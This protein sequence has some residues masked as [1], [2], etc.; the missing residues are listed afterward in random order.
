MPL[1]KSEK[2]Y[3]HTIE[4]WEQQLYDYEPTYGEMVYKRFMDRGISLLPDTTKESLF[5]ILDSS[6][7][8][9]HS[10]L[11][12]STF[13]KNVSEKIMQTARLFNE[14]IFSLEDM[15]KLTLDQ[16]NFIVKE[17][18]ARY[19]M[20]AFGQGCTTGI[21]KSSLLLTDILAILVINLR[22]IQVIASIYGRPA[23]SP[24][25][26]M[27]VLKVF[28]A[29][30]LPKELQGEAW[31][32]LMEDLYKQDYFYKGKEE[33]VDESTF[34]LLVKQSVKLLCI[35]FFS[36]KS[37][38][39]GMIVGSGANYQFTRKITEFTHK[40][41]QKSYLLLKDMEESPPNH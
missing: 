32:E 8:Y 40:Y 30:C 25:E 19:R 35:Y 34:L 29:A 41:Y 11:F 18:I 3:L 20:L 12:N 5:I 22:A 2:Y 36:K 4:K 14:E 23:I 17:Q 38:T 39:I 33:I 6:L 1:T 21:G 24:Y 37:S 26:I 9:V 10:I 16:L 15:N 13:Q 27:A 7:F 28:H 31:I